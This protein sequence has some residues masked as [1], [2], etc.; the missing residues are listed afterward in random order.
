MRAHGLLWW[1]WL[2][3]LLGHTR[4]LR[5]ESIARVVIV[6]PAAGDTLLNEALIRT[7]GELRAVG[8]T[9]EIQLAEERALSRLPESV[10][11][12]LVF[13]RSN[14]RIEIEAFAPGVD[15]PVLQVVDTAQP[16]VDAEVVSVRA[17]E[18]LRAAMLQYARRARA[19]EQALPE[20]VVG[21]TKLDRPKQDAL[22][23]KE[24]DEPHDAEQAEP[25]QERAAPSTARESDAVRWSVWL[26][27]ELSLDVEPS[28]PNLGGRLAGFA[29]W[30]SV[31][32]G[33][34]VEHGFGARDVEANEG[35]ASVQRSGAL[36]HAKL[37]LRLSS[38]VSPYVAVGFGV[39]R[40]QVTGAADHGK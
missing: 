19:S 35:S 40:Y 24:P 7:R 33:I 25:S 15:A 14:G 28:L 9:V 26:G 1:I 20:A 29:A 22:A 36:A 13:R 34:S 21:F 11:G 18:A 12:T 30:R 8:L 17:V 37:E 2:L 38:S 4:V 6:R 3:L 10:Y 16:S 32:A 39:R 23:S 31:A 5:A 27:P